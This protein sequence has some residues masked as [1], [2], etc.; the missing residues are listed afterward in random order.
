MRIRKNYT[1]SFYLPFVLNFLCLEHISY[2]KKVFSNANYRSYYHLDYKRIYYELKTQTKSGVYWRGTKIY[3]RRRIMENGL[4]NN[5]FPELIVVPKSTEDVAKI[6]K[7]S[8]KYKIP[9]SVRSGGHSYHCASIKPFGIHIDMRS[10]NK[11]E[12]TTRD[13]FGPPGPALLL[14]PGQTWGR[15]LK[16]YPVSYTHLTLPTILR[17]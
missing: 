8:R 11:V 6:V 3:N 7:I 1:T 4:C 16:F 2:S 15:V 9:I 13:P 10:F 12:L 14:G 5:I 17:V